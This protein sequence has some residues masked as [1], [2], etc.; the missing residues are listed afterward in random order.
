M[1]LV[2]IQNLRVSRL[3]KKNIF[4]AYSMQIQEALDLLASQDAVSTAALAEATNLLQFS[5][6]ISTLQTLASIAFD[7]TQSEARRE[8]SLVILR[9]RLLG[10][11]STSN[12]TLRASIEEG[13]V[14]CL[15]ASS[16]SQVHWRVASVISAILCSQEDAWPRLSTSV[17][18]FLLGPLE[19]QD[20]ITVAL[21][22][23]KA[24]YTDGAPKFLKSFPEEVEQL[25]TKSLT[26][27]HSALRDLA[28]RTALV[29]IEYY[30]TNAS[31]PEGGRRLLSVFLSVICP[32]DVSAYMLPLLESL[33]NVLSTSLYVSEVSTQKSS[34]WNAEGAA[35]ISRIIDSTHSDF[36]AS[37]IKQ[38]V[39]QLAVSCYCSSPQGQSLLLQQ[40]WTYLV[41]MLASPVPS[42]SMTPECIRDC[43]ISWQLKR[44]D[45]ETALSD[46]E[47]ADGSVDVTLIAWEQLDRLLT[48]LPYAESKNLA[49]QT[50]NRLLEEKLG[51]LQTYC[52]YYAA[53]MILSVFVGCKGNQVEK[54]LLLP[55]LN[56]WKTAV[57][58]TTDQ[59]DVIIQHTVSRIRWACLL[60]VNEVFDQFE[61]LPISDEDAL[62]TVGMLGAAI[63]GEPAPRVKAKFILAFCQL[64]ANIETETETPLVMDQALEKILLPLSRRAQVL[65][66]ASFPEDFAKDFF[67]CSVCLKELV[68]GAIA[69]TVPKLDQALLCKYYPSV[70][71]DCHTV[72]NQ[73]PDS[74]VKEAEHIC[75]AVL[76]VARR[77]VETASLKCGEVETETDSAAVRLLRERFPED[78]VYILRKIVQL[79]E[80]QGSSE[81][82]P[83]DQIL[84][85]GIYASS[86]ERTL[87]QV[88]ASVVAVLEP[89]AMGTEFRQ[90]LRIV[91]RKLQANDTISVQDDLNLGQALN[92]AEIR[93]N[94]VST[95]VVLQQQKG[96]QKTI[97]INTSLLE[98]QVASLSF[99]G[100]TA[101]KI[102]TCIT[103]EEA[104]RMLMLI[105]GVC[106]SSLIGMVR[107][108]AVET[109]GEI[110][111]V[112]IEKFTVAANDTQ[113]LTSGF[114]IWS[115]PD[116]RDSF[117]DYVAKL[118]RFLR[119]SMDCLCTGGDSKQDNDILYCMADMCDGLR[120]AY[121]YNN[122]PF[123]DWPVVLL[124]AFKVR[125]LFAALVDPL[126]ARIGSSI[127]NAMAADEDEND[128]ETSFAKTDPPD[129]IF[130]VRC[131]A[132][133]QLISR[134]SKV[135]AKWIVEPF[136]KH[137]KVYY[138][139]VLAMEDVSVVART[140]AL[141]VF[142]NYVE[143]SG[144]DA[145]H[146]LPVACVYC[147][148]SEIPAAAANLMR[149]ALP[150]GVRK[151]DKRAVELE[152][153]KDY[154]LPIATEL[155]TIF[156]DTSK[157]PEEFT[158]A[159]EASLHSEVM[160]IQAA[161]YCVGMCCLYGTADFVNHLPQIDEA[162]ANLLD[163][164]LAGLSN[165]RV[166]L[167]CLGCAAL[168]IFIKLDAP[169]V[170]AS[171]MKIFSYSGLLKILQFCFPLWADFEDGCVSH[172]IIIS[173]V[174][175]PTG[176]GA[177][178]CL[179]ALTGS[180]IHSDIK[181]EIQLEVA[182]ILTSLRDD[183]DAELTL[184]FQAKNCGKLAQ[185]LAALGIP[186][187]IV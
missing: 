84:K 23:L 51:P 103:A 98:E 87:L 117:A 4:R 168:K 27:E 165:R 178:P 37:S 161:C 46:F 170:S 52:H 146:I 19:T 95:T 166:I 21:C 1:N 56:A 78:A 137:L 136:D 15:L 75:E 162:F 119:V 159:Y 187:S 57:E 9:S 86:F 154:L 104:D 128:P 186:A 30:V 40:I 82:G 120:D 173:W 156:E 65:D 48:M 59:P 179:Y 41:S 175:S 118:A 17:Q 10:W 3:H 143:A 61:A 97:N 31:M 181:S 11:D 92:R 29:A 125:E 172:D 42:P 5:D 34:P 185:A 144:I 132:A 81:P 60:F 22:L 171:K 85:T 99:I 177:L 131:D 35:L 150:F 24:I 116:V 107:K 73:I 135:F 180:M 94:D 164:P 72:L 176:I 62:K 26:S 79:D 36:T 83:S 101:E 184:S 53:W 77:L 14:E 124:E 105:E 130:G 71:A 55:L 80:H 50:A 122:T 151:M 70:M 121:N 74:A 106:R 140:S 152:D 153:T 49:T 115:N 155:R 100:V 44:D 123:T 76:E 12:E 13:L 167:D 182:R 88:A 8:S 145:D 69:V 111:R 90:L 141:C 174:T 113:N 47:L 126:F 183:E 25:L 114:D 18:M 138:G 64:V 32:T 66:A 93:K 58:T 45:E 67:A 158:A 63:L 160:R 89:E 157:S 2:S 102:H 147:R 149:T 112:L 20:K 133:M 109:L 110:A 28:S 127:K 54:E 134:L 7:P 68:L 163:H 38:Y 139:T 96:T 169:A 148:S 6:N 108:S 33:A 39:S 142:A 43:I 129:D 91:Q 16:N